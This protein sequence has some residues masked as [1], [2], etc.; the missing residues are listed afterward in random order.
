[1]SLLQEREITGNLS[2]ISKKY[3]F[4]FR[5]EKRRKEIE[6]LIKI[7]L[8]YNRNTFFLEKHPI[9]QNYQNYSIDEFYCF[10]L[11]YIPETLQNQPEELR[12]IVDQYLFSILLSFDEE[13]ERITYRDYS[14]YHLK[15]IQY[16][17]SKRIPITFL[18]S[19][20]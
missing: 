10:V 13:G 4:F 7:L 5:E 11:L 14:Q 19:R 18:R 3:G 6:E 17:N 16:P 2:K 20:D 12:N 8:K 15:T 9:H 1:M